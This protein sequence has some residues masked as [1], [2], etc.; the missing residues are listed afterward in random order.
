[1]PYA[2]KRP[3]PWRRTPLPPEWARLRLEILDRDGRVCQIQGPRCEGTAREVDHIRPGDD[4]DP[5][6]LQSACGPCH[7]TKT[8][9][10]N[11]AR[12]NRP[13]RREPEPHPGIIQPDE[14]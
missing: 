2:N 9:R 12:V 7:R 6:N 5:S 3:G 4:H 10:E 13:R 8:G 11:A 14:Q 1:M